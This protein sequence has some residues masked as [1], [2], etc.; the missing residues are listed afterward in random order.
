MCCRGGETLPATH[1]PTLSNGDFLSNS[2]ENKRLCY[3]IPGTKRRVEHRATP[4]PNDSSLLSGS[5]IHRTRQSYTF[6]SCVCE[7]LDLQSLYPQYLAL[8]E[9]FQ[10]VSERARER[11]AVGR[12]AA[13]FVVSCDTAERSPLTSSLHFLQ[14][15][16]TAHPTDESQSVASRLEHFCCCRA[17]ESPDCLLRILC[18][19]CG[20]E[21]ADPLKPALV[22][23]DR[24]IADSCLGRHS[25]FGNCDH[26]RTTWE[27]WHKQWEQDRSD[28]RVY[29]TSK[30]GMNAATTGC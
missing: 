4:D 17:I 5:Q 11:V 24:P 20:Q 27:T 1:F 9:C 13:A 23:E 6:Q 12:R 26:D 22:H 21:L 16:E 3:V 25:S 19:E 8:R 30:M 28:E 2:G 15:S 29:V 18:L 7:P 14:S 10:L